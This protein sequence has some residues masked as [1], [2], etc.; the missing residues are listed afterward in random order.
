M[1]CTCHKEIAKE[2]EKR[3]YSIYYIFALIFAS[4]DKNVFK[5]CGGDMK[6]NKKF[7]AIF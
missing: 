1:C 7:T 5:K 4:Y 2:K 3:R 6:Q